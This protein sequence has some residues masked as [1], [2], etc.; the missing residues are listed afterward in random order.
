MLLARTADT[1]LMGERAYSLRFYEQH[2]GWRRIA[3]GRYD[4]SR[5]GHAILGPVISSTSKWIEREAH[6]ITGA[7]ISRARGGWIS[8]WGGTNPS[9]FN[10]DVQIVE[11]QSS[12]GWALPC[13]QSLADES[14]KQWVVHVHGRGA[15]T[16]ETARNFKFVAGQGFNNLGLHFRGD[17][18]S[19]RDGE[20]RGARLGLGTTEWVDL[21]A[22]VGHLVTAGA[23]KIFVVAWSYGAAVSLQFANKSKLAPFVGGYFFDSPVISWRET[24]RFQAN[25]S[26]APRH[27][28]LLGE[29]F[30]SSK[31]G[32]RSIGLAS[33]IDF[34]EFEARAI[35]PTIAKPIVMAHSVDDGFIPIGPA[36]DLARL[37]PELVELVEFDG[38]R[39]CKLVNHEPKR[40]ESA[41]ARLIA[42]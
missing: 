27:F 26:R 19:R 5:L 1:V 37:R 41:L 17:Y 21:E 16:A 24:L 38:A 20:I 23:T 34:D 40:Y 15:T 12:D 32:S 14:S 22:A 3:H 11:I 39:H 29:R 13:W 28:A 42:K 8:G 6:T 7:D 31:S 30:I 35:A 33:P 2:R 36:R 25:L 4:Y 18:V 10:I 9:D